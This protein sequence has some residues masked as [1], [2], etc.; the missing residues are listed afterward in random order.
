MYR[1]WLLLR[2][3]GLQ[4][5]RDEQAAPC[6]LGVYRPTTPKAMTGSI[7]KY[8]LQNIRHQMQEGKNDV[9]YEQTTS[10]IDLQ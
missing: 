8:R 7:T 3:K 9:C 4:A 2:E 10:A 5:D 1:A 6:V